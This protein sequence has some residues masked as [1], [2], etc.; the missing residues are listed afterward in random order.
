ML[1]KFR[2]DIFHFNLDNFTEK[3][4]GQD[5][6]DGEKTKKSSS[7]KVHGSGEQ[8][9][10]SCAEETTAK[11]EDQA[12]SG[13]VEGDQAAPENYET[14]H[15]EMADGKVCV[16]F[17]ISH[18]IVFLCIFTPMFQLRN[19]NSLIFILRYDS[20]YMYMYGEKVS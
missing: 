2:E 17:L 12:G 11:T 3:N 9:T 16:F 6:A 5:Q 13:S 19:D 14:H 20:Q 8:A 10:S 15:L 1:F 18:I 4:N 7:R